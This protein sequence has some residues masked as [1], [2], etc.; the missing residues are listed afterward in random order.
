[1]PYQITTASSI[2]DVCSQIAAFAV[3][4]AGFTNEG[5]V[6]ISSRVV[7]RLSKNGMYYHFCHNFN[8]TNWMRMTP[9]KELFTTDWKNYDNN[10]SLY[11]GPYPKSISYMS[12][13]AFAGPYPGLYCFTDGKVVHVVVELTNGIYNHMS[14][15]E[16]TKTD[17][18]VGGEFMTCGYYQYISG[19]LY[20]DLNI[21]SNGNSPPWL[22]DVYVGLSSQYPNWMYA[23]AASGVLGNRFDWI[24]FGNRYGSDRLSGV[25]AQNR[26]GNQK[27]LLQRS[28]NTG[29]LRSVMFPQLLDIY[30]SVSG[31]NKPAGHIP[32][33]RVVNMK[34]LD[35]KEVIYTDWQVF[36]ITQRNGSRVNICNSEEY[37]FAYKR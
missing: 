32:N 21:S 2:P 28:P 6:T 33:M 27:V 17:T 13:Q 34:A 7:Q 8:G 31:L 10:T 23:P 5:T 19:G 11:T 26:D 9:S 3:A 37:A 22:N 14:F 12:F 24:P 4:N 36:P 29:T 20:G 15:G 16:M 1:M 30:D 35:E 18:F 25:R